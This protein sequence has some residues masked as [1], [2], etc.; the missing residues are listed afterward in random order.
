V[1]GM[2]WSARGGSGLECGGQRVDWAVK[3]AAGGLP[4]KAA[5]TTEACSSRL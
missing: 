2:G 5:T 1:A 4:T 3:T